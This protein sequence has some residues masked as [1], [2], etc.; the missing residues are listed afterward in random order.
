[1]RKL[2]GLVI[3]AGLIFGVVLAIGT[4]RDELTAVALGA[5]ATLSVSATPAIVNVRRI[6]VDLGSWTY[7][8]AEQFSSNV[9]MNPGF[10]PNIDRAIVIV[11]DTSAAGFSDDSSWLGRPNNFWNGATFQVRTG[12]SAGYFGTIAS[13]LQAASDGLPWF[14]TANPAPVLAPGDVISVLTTQNS[15]VPANWWIPGSPTGYVAINTSD[16]RPGSPGHSVAQMTLQSG[17]PTEIDSYLDSMD[18]T[19]GATKFLPINGPWQLSFW[20][21]ATS[22][23]PSMSVNFSRLG[24]SSSVSFVSQSIAVSAAWQQTVINF[25]ASDTGP[26][27]TLALSFIASGAAGSQVRLDDVTL[28]RAS[29]LPNAFRAEVVG[30][31]TA[32]HPSYLRDWQSQLGDTLT[33]RLAS[34]FARSPARYRPD[35]DG[36][37]QLF[38]YSLPD[39][40]A[41]CNQIGAQPWIVLPTTFYDSEFAALGTYLAN[42]QTTYNFSEIVVEFGNENWNSDFRPAGIENPVPMGQLANRTFSVIRQAAGS[43]VPLHFEVNS[44]FVNP[45]IG[46]QALANAPSANAADVGP[47]FFYTLNAGTAQSA[48]IASMMIDDESALLA[49]LALTTTPLG[50]AIDVYEVNLSTFDGTAP[51]SQRTPLVAG[52]V[53]GTALA[54]RLMLGMNAGI[55]RQCVWSLSQY[56]NYLSA[57]AGYMR[58]FGITHDLTTASSFRPTGLALEMMNQAIEGDFHPVTIAGVTG[59]TAVAFRSSA[60]W[61]MAIASSNPGVTHVAVGFPTGATLPTRLLTLNSSSITATNETGKNVTIAQTTLAQGFQN[62]SVPGDGFIVLLPPGNPS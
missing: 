1:M 2:T 33:N 52:A 20:S 47:Y 57:S 25:T 46:Q 41:L 62:I 56:D 9:L 13:S 43:S 21:R 36:S 23:T 32:L 35:P 61:S 59:L 28:E 11:H 55:L 24:P 54:R 17:Q 38:L 10:E 8:G 22:G 7:Y 26:A 4:R 48:A 60:G 19:D 53:S 16:H 34:T 18:G 42:A 27:G 31:L 6:G 39:F 12:Q 15:G 49:Q 29:D 3:G 58:L 45:W 30:A 50:K 14:S 44:Q 40:L 5:P 37:Q 51:E